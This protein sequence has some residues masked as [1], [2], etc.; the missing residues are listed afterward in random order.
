[1]NSQTQKLLN[2][3]E[4]YL[5]S[6][7]P[8]IKITGSALTESNFL[9]VT[10]EFVEFKQHEA[11]LVAPGWSGLGFDELIQ[12]LIT[13]IKQLQTNSVGESVH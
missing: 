7:M 1:M 6:S 4:A 5:E 10:F 2:K 12:N 8:N 11:L 13:K 3:I 9:V